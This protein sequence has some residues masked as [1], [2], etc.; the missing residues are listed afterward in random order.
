M[1]EVLFRGV[2]FAPLALELAEAAVDG[3]LQTPF[4]HAC[5]QWREFGQDLL[6]FVQLTASLEGSCKV[7]EDLCGR[8]VVAKV[9]LHPV[10]LGCEPDRLAWVTA[11]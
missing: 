9:S 8:E 2:V 11:D 10:G 3:R 5:D 6:G 1:P 4:G 7:E